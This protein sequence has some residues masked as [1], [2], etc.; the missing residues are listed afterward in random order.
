MINDAA[1]TVVAL[2]HQYPAPLANVLSRARAVLVYPTILQAGF[3]VGGSGGPGVLLVRQ[4]DGSWSNPVFYGFASASVGL[5]VGAQD[6]AVLIAIMT[7]RGL[8]KLMENNVKLGAD[9]SFAAGPVGAGL[10]AGTTNGG[11]DMYVY[12]KD[13]GL[14]AGGAL[15][16]ALITPSIDRDKEYYGGRATQRGILTSARKSKGSDSLRAALSSAKRAAMN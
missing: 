13:A 11:P 12:S 10:E 2:R 9:A 7:D 15:N 1:H 5:Q 6:K 3:I 14:F 4:A 16:G 8:Q